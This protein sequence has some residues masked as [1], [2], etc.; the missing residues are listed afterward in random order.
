LLAAGRRLAE[1]DRYARGPNFLRYDPSF[2]LG[3]EIHG[4]TL[5]IIGMGRIGE[6]VAKRA[7]GFEM[8]VLYHNRNRKPAAESALGVRFVARDELLSTADYIMLTV[9]LTKETTGLSG[10]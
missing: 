5:G 9:P 4:S 2:M 1:G 6:Q 10:R 8:S 3:R 7:R